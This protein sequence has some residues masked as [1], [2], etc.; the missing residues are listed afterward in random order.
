MIAYRDPDAD[1]CPCGCPL[2][3]EMCS[4]CDAEEIAASELFWALMSADPPKDTGD[5]PKGRER[6]AGP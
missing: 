3:G 6:S 1:Y 4:H 5:G 2:V